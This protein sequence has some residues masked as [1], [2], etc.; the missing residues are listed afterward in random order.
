MSTRKRAVVIGCGMISKNH[1]KALQNI[2]NAEI[3]G[4]C[5]I[6]REKALQTAAEYGVT[7]VCDDYR[8]FLTDDEADVIHICTPHHLHSQMARDALAAGKHV[9]CEKPMALTEADARA[10]I[11][12]RDCSC[13]QL[14]VCFQNRFNRASV[15]MKNVMDSGKLG[16]LIGAR[17]QVTWDRK[18]EYYENSSWRGRWESEGGGV[19]INQ[20]IHTFDLLQW[21][22]CDIKKVE[23]SISTKRLKPVI[24]VE[25]TADILMTG[26]NGE[27][28]LFY[29]S[30][31]YVKNAP[32]EIEIICESGNLKMKGSKVTTELEGTVTETDFSSGVVL[33]KDYWGSGHGFLIRDFY[34]CIETGRTFSVSGEEA[35]VSVR[36]LEAVYRS[37]KKGEAIEV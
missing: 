3:Y 2:D 8:R 33:G 22:T 28:L 29:A 7:K 23:A 1:L 32:A 13:R 19:L 35:L 21:L 16:R 18:P 20:A 25:D 4:L 9:L 24:E 27:R 15:Y 26:A 5:D 6:D 17:A 36:L 11:E 37:G 12:A 14:A 31:C 30:N 10:M 34:D